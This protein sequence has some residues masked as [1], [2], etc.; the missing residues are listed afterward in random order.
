[1]N[2]AA[3]LPELPTNSESKFKETLRQNLRFIKSLLYITK[4]LFML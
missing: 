4:K 3:N 2:Y 1:M